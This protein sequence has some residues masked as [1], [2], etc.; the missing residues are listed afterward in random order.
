ME[1]YQVKF[2]DALI[3]VRERRLN[4]VIDRPVEVVN[5]S[6]S[7]WGTDDELT[8]LTRHGIRFQPD[9][10]LVGMTLHNDVE[11]LSLQR[12]KRVISN[13]EFGPWPGP[14]FLSAPARPAQGAADGRVGPPVDVR[15]DSG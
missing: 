11:S 10:V 9:L 6:V 2:A 15:E 4:E 13:G 5:A 1:A 8:Y 14:R 3:S 12:P 7:G